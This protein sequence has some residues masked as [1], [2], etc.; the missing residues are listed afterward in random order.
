[1]LLNALN[2]SCVNFQ[3]PVMPQVRGAL[4]DGSRLTTEQNRRLAEN[5]IPHLNNE[6]RHIFRLI[7]DLII[8]LDHVS[9]NDNCYFIDG[10]AGTGKTFLLSV[11]NIHQPILKLLVI[12]K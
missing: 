4:N 3:L 8:N 5:N 7:T 6:Q 1:M 2:L 11:T 10:P 12:F 9:N